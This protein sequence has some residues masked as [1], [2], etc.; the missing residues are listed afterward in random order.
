[1][2]TSLLQES[3]VE[4]LNEPIANSPFETAQLCQSHQYPGM[5]T[6]VLPENN[7]NVSDGL[8]LASA[9][10]EFALNDIPWNT[11]KKRMVCELTQNTDAFALENQLRH[12]LVAG[13]LT[14]QSD[15]DLHDIWKTASSSIPPPITHQQSTSS[16]PAS[17]F[18][19]YRFLAWAVHLVS[20]KMVNEEYS[21]KA[22]CPDICNILLNRIPKSILVGLFRINI[23]TVRATWEFLVYCAGTFAYRDSFNF[24]IRAGLQHT[25]WVVPR[26]ASYLG[27]A[28]CMGALDIVRDLLKAGARADGDIGIYEQ[29]PLVEAAATGNLECMK[30]LLDKCDTNRVVR[31]K[32]G[33]TFELF[34]RTLER[35][36]FFV[37][38][39]QDH[40]YLPGSFHQLTGQ[41][42][43][44][45]IGFTNDIYI[46]A[47]AML[48]EDSKILGAEI[49]LGDASFREPRLMK[50]YE[51]RSTP[52]EWYPTILESIYYKNRDL[53]WKVIPYSTRRMECATR[54]GIWLSAKQGQNFLNEY[55][56]SRPSATASDMTEFLEL[57]LAEHFMM[58]NMI[59]DMKVVR[60]LIEFGVDPNRASFPKNINYFLC[61]LVHQACFI[62]Y[63]CPDDDFGGDT[64]EDPVE[65]FIIVLKLLLHYGAVIDEEVLETGIQWGGLDTLLVLAQHG[66]D[67][68]NY[69]GAALSR[70]AYL[71]NYEAVSWLLN[72]GVD[73]NA[74][75]RRENSQHCSVIAKAIVP[76]HHYL[77]WEDSLYSGSASCEMT[78]HLIERGANLKNH[79]EQPTMFYFLRD[80][81][82]L[83]RKDRDMVDKME[84]FLDL[85][86]DVG[87]LLGPGCLLRSCLGSH[88]HL[89][90]Q[91]REQR[92][93]IF[94]LLLE[95][96][97]PAT[98]HCVLPSLIY[99]GGRHETIRKLIEDGMDINIYSRRLEGSIFTPLQAA[100][101]RGDNALVM[102]LV[103]M[104]ADINKLAAGT[105]GKTALQA[106]CGLKLT[107]TEERTKKVELIQFLIERGADINAPAALNNGSTALQCAAT[108]GDIEVALLL[109][110]HGAKVN[111]L[112]AT[113]KG[114]F[115]AL[116]AA[117]HNGRLDM[118]KLL[119]NVGALSHHKGESGY[120]GAIDLAEAARH[121][122]VADL[123]REHAENNMK[124]YG[125]NLAMTF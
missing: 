75:V 16:H 41:G 106:A 40:A 7:I 47:F 94:E 6:N 65:N 90:E 96:G 46:H 21:H 5:S 8:K 114:G 115:C 67:V 12:L 39:R 123:I 66:A 74:T 79:P 72:A 105:N 11:L 121:S 97:A 27:F 100:S 18:D 102:E 107:T 25:G 37:P 43:H 51:R 68:S 15:V 69:G 110:D 3:C 56:M 57:V 122:V 50:F 9:N 19:L 33:T 60:G 4:P 24:L 36:V 1:M 31:S 81:L 112:P 86:S 119:L 58:R 95:R 64:E 2:S 17:N 82:I 44:I 101:H 113:K 28:A 118:V 48:L 117:A 22:H 26:G 108:V 103:L 14:P 116:D 42:L 34:A 70:A 52:M 76:R 63:R 61:H 93:A 23:P 77:E 83:A 53:F 29:S 78:E 13:H 84:L 89:T 62:S 98:D 124:L 109:L 92:L 35:G 125:V 54:S 30:L 73:I 87:D 111:T 55:L 59:V 88:L 38:L 120:Q 71:D 104:G 20:N 49:G 10:Y 99:Y 32:N 80:Y 85:T 45:C 91:E